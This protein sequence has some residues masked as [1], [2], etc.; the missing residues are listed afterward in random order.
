[1]QPTLVG[2]VSTASSLKARYGC[3]IAFSPGSCGSPSDSEIADPAIAA[4]TAWQN[5]PLNTTVRSTGYHWDGTQLVATS[6]CGIRDTIILLPGMYPD[7]N[8]IN[9]YTS[10]TA[11]KESTIWL[12]PEAGTDG[13]LLTDDDKTGAYYFGFTNGNTD[14]SCSDLSANAH[15]LCIGGGSA[16]SSP[17]VVAGTP[18]G[19]NPLGVPGATTPRI[20]T[21]D[22]AQTID[23]GLS[24]SWFSGGNARTIDG[25]VANY[26]ATFCLFG[27]CISS[28]RSIRLRDFAPQV[29]QGPDASANTI[30]IEVGHRETGS[31]DTPTVEV[32]TVSPES[33]SRTCPGT[34][35]LPTNNT[36]SIHVDKLQYNGS[37]SQAAS[38]VA[39]CLDSADR[40]NGLQ[41]TFR[42]TGNSFNSGSP[43]VYLDGARVSFQTTPGASFPICRSGRT[44]RRHRLRQDQGRRAADL[45]R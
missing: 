7:A 8:T 24:Q 26:Q 28:N 3:A 6:T 35:T 16:D 17:R 23:S 38:R 22:T 45:R 9:R 2:G 5:V 21:M 1:M 36:G 32:R 13:I 27:I 25:N 14:W 10:N 41:L 29:A 12:A 20:V 31:M 34:Y 19:W 44:G 30:N 11:C 15:R 4:P 40:I 18:D 43:R 42:W 37:E 39:Q 33:G